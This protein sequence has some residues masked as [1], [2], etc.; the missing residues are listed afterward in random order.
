M[1]LKLNS[2]I[3]Y[4]QPLLEL[5][6]SPNNSLLL[7]GHEKDYKIIREVILIALR[8]LYSGGLLSMWQ[9]GT[10]KK[11]VGMSANRTLKWL[12]SCH[13]CHALEQ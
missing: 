4:S 2:E 8:G 11:I 3:L 5:S 12:S 13:F 7:N 9:R 10:Q 6:R 1:D